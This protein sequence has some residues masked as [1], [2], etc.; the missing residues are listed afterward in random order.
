MT[1]NRSEAAFE[2]LA[3]HPVDVV[4]CD[5]RMPGMDG[6]EFLSRTR[7]MHPHAQRI[8]F[9]GHRDFEAATSA[10]NRGAIHKFLTKPVDFRELKEILSEAFQNAARRI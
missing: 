10:I 9:S 8:I 1:A 3:A 2:L 5:L 6:V 7:R 4:L